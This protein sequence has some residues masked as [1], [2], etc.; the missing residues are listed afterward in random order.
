MFQMYQRTLY[1]LINLL[2]LHITI[3]FTL[4]LYS[5]ISKWIYI[6]RKY[7]HLSQ[8]VY[9][10]TSGNETYCRQVYVCGDCQI[11]TQAK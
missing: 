11:C 9:Y 4:K 10:V 5:G 7:G 6:P 3:M 2:T 8:R 1:L